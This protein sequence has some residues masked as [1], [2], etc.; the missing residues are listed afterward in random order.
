MVMGFRFPNERWYIFITKQVLVLV[1]CR[2]D[3]DPY[4]QINIITVIAFHTYRILSLKY[5]KLTNED[6]YVAKIS[7]NYLF[8]ISFRPF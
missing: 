1:H 4:R 3:V 2:L 7:E 8:S 5:V 6:V